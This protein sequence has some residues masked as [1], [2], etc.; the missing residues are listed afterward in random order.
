MVCYGISGV[1]SSLRWG[2]FEDS[3]AEKIYKRED[4]FPR[5]CEHHSL[6]RQRGLVVYLN[7]LSIDQ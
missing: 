7:E 2:N 3:Q 4:L 1:V 6:H 5:D